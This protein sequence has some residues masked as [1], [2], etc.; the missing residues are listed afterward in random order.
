MMLRTTGLIN[1]LRVIR[2]PVSGRAMIVRFCS[3]C[4]TFQDVMIEK[5]TLLNYSNY[6]EN[7]LIVID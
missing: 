6:F 7:K 4:S 5:S 1:W 2:M 3:E